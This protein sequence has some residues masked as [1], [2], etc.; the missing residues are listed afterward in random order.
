MSGGGTSERG[1]VMW[2][3]HELED[4]VVR[5]SNDHHSAQPFCVGKLRGTRRP[6][7]FD[8]CLLSSMISFLLMLLVSGPTSTTHTRH[9]AWRHRRAA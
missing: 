6:I 4:S 8:A 7:Y 3:R 1:I 5:R 2:K 9:R